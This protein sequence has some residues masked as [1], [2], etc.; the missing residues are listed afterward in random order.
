MS[1]ELNKILNEAL[2]RWAKLTGTKLGTHSYTFNLGSD[3]EFQDYDLKTYV[4][5]L[6]A[7]RSLDV[8]GT[9]AILLLRGLLEAY[10]KERALKIHALLFA[11]QEVEATL[12]EMRAFHALITRPPCEEAV[13]E[14]R[15][16]VREAAAHYGYDLGKLKDLLAD[17][18]ALGELRLAA[19]RSC[20]TLVVHQFAQGKPTPDPLQYNREIFEFTSINSFVHAL[21]RQW[22]SGITLALIRNTSDTRGVFKAFFVLG[23]RNGENITILTDRQ[24]VAHPEYHNITRRPERQLDARARCHWFPYRLLDEDPVK[25]GEDPATHG[26]D[27]SKRGEDPSKRAKRKAALV[28]KD[29]RTVPV[30]KISELEPPEFIWLTLLFGLLTEAYGKDFRT[31]ELSYTGE[32]VI[33]PHALLDSSH[34]LVTTKQYPPPLILAK[35]TV[36]TA[37]VAAA[38]NRTPV[39]HNAW[40]EDRYKGR[41]PEI[42]LNVVGKNQSLE[43]EK[44]AARLL[45][46]DADKSELPPMRRER[47]VLCHRGPDHRKTELSPHALDPTCFG[48]RAQIE[49]DRVWAA[50]MNM[51]QVIQKLAVDEFVKKHELVLR[52]YR[53]RVAQNMA[54]L[55]KAVAQGELI[56]PTLRW[57]SNGPNSFPSHDTRVWGKAN[58]LQQKIGTRLRDVFAGSFQ[59]LGIE[60]GAWNSDRHCV[61]C[62]KD[63]SQRAS[64]FTLIEPDNPR[65]LA[66][67]C[68]IPE[69]RLP[70][71]LQNWCTSE[72][73]IGNS[74]LDRVDPQDWKLD[75]PWRHLELR[76]SIALCKRE[77]LR[78]RK[79]HG[80]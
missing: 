36:E 72:P 65:A 61:T 52:W 43:A 58:I 16:A 24:E 34:A 75:N 42:L 54:F 10:V 22:I 80:L 56:A 64:V 78:L 39:G 27:S 4:S 53:A 60:I 23:L 67:L 40:M 69:S 11:P 5:D 45:P 59:D 6:N 12:L 73:Y 77:F 33:E 68:G 35:L 49:R 57:K 32:M 63:P 26:E 50:R 7:A 76:I 48:T 19:A 14:F 30:A 9:T 25:R 37:T 18:R 13:L 74:I 79:E 17:E 38:D 31:Q 66:L 15:K 41:V 47:G 3:S 55:W 46:G 71:P 51:M 29:A 62:G 70:W 1:D 20:E 44:Q 8:S 21:H 2:P 28:S